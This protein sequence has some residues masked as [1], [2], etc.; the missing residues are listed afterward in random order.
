MA[1]TLNDL[2]N[3]KGEKISFTEGDTTTTQ[4]ESFHGENVELEVASIEQ[5]FD[6]EK[7][8]SIESLIFPEQE[9]LCSTDE[10]IKISDTKVFPWKA[11]CRL[12]ITMDDGRVG[13]GTGWLNGA[14]TIITAGHCVFDSRQGKKKWH[15]SIVV[16]PG[17]DNTKEPYGRFTITNNNFWS[18]TG[19]T[20]NGDPDYDYGA[21]LL[22]NKIG[23]KIGYFG[24]RYDPDEAIKDKK[25]VNTGYPADKLGSLIDTQWHMKDGI[26]SLTSRKVFYMLDTF[27]GNSGGPVYLDDNNHQCI[28]IHAYGGC[29]NSGTRINKAVYTNLLKWKQM[30]N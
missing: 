14:G 29:A 16:I 5:E 1:D 9:D 20:Q 30:G 13:V 11:V 3:G 8:P 7:L 27:G 4:S 21:I 24:F 10:R 25:I 26:Q 28:C 12:I 18:V 15:K 23:N 22:G 6:V 19:W 2:V 17:K